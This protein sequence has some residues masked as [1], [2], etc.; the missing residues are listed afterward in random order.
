MF[1]IGIRYV[2][3]EHQGTVYEPQGEISWTPWYNVFTSRRDLTK[4]RFHEYHDAM[5][6]SQGETSRKLR[7]SAFTSRKDFMNTRY[8]VFTL[9]QDGLDDTS[10]VILQSTNLHCIPLLQRELDD[11]SRGILHS[12]REL[13]LSTQKKLSPPS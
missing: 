10:R 3:Y 4:E 13:V 2:L 1:C 12:A 8:N 7:Y 9:L 5:Y 6:P 11:T